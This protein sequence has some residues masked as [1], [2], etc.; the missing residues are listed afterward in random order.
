MMLSLLA[1]SVLLNMG[2][3]LIEDSLLLFLFVALETVLQR[4]YASYFILL[5]VLDGCSPRT[6]LY[7]ILNFSMLFCFFAFLLVRGVI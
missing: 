6:Y 3:I 4:T 1:V 2:S 5:F 7:Q